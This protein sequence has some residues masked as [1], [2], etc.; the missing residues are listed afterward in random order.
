MKVVFVE[1]KQKSRFWDG[2]ADFLEKNGHAVFWIVQNPWIKPKTGEVHKIQL[3]TS[4]DLKND[5]SFDWLKKRDRH[6]YVYNGS[7]VHYSYYSDKIE[8]ILGTISPD[9]VFGEITLFHEQIAANLCR[10]RGIPYFVP[11]SS[12]YPAGR[13][14]F[15]EYDTL[16]TWGGSGEVVSDSECMALVN[17]INERSTTPDYMPSRGFFSTG[18]FL[19]RRS[20]GLCFSLWSSEVIGERYNT[21]RFRDKFYITLAARTCRRELQK[22]AINDLNSFSPEYTLVVPLQ[23]QPESNID[24]WGAG[25]SNQASVL[26]D[27]LTG[28]PNHWNILVKTNPK[29]KYELNNQLASL[30]VGRGNLHFL[31]D[32]INMS[33]LLKRFK[34]FYSA[35]GTIL[36]EAVFSGRVAFSPVMPIIKALRPKQSFVPTLEVVESSTSFHQVEAINFV[37]K[38]V[39][40]S[41]IGLIGDPVHGPNAMNKKNLE[42]VAEG[43]LDLMDKLDGSKV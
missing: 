21:P 26:Q 22:F 1:N 43:F 10:A 24:V 41:Y 32:S 31:D 34:Y 39:S 38:L 16:N 9:V 11:A 27:I 20:L 25:Y 2:V 8:E 19:L 17:S 40:E 36:F 33:E 29:A 30:V 28:L 18:T 13:F 5:N 37:K 35:T 14:C 42:R 15:H 6:C 12:R 4:K 3:P 7:G 23:M